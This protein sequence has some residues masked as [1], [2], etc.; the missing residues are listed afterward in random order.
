MIRAAWRPCVFDYDFFRMDL[1][2]SRSI[3]S[4]TAVAIYLGQI[5]ARVPNG[6]LVD[7][8]ISRPR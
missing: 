6:M 4:P 1:A 5:G 8:I 7:G 2:A 3:T